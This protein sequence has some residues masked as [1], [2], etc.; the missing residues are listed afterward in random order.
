MF[1]RL[2]NYCVRKAQ[3]ILSADMNLYYP[4]KISTM[5]KNKVIE[6]L[7]VDSSIFMC[8]SQRLKVE[9][10]RCLR[11]VYPKQ[12]KLTIRQ[13]RKM[14]PRLGQLLRARTQDILSADMY[15]YYS[16]KISTMRRNKVI[17]E[18]MVDSSIFMCGSQRLKLEFTRCLRYAYPNQKKR[19]IREKPQNVSPSGATSACENP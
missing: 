19:T 5:R 1:P 14:F 12:K 17:E 9:L 8:G 7:M 15:L 16:E 11:Y 18:L 3:D 13:N 10:T 4:E 6:E 2:G